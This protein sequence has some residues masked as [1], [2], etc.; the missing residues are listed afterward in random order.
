M[1]LSTHKITNLGYF[2]AITL[3]VSCNCRPKLKALKNSDLETN[4]KKALSIDKLQPPDHLEGVRF[5]QDGMLNKD[6]HKEAFIGN[7]EEIDEE[8]AE[9]ADSKLKDIFNK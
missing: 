5:E 4:S 7:H 9:I 8:P 6:F 2:I 3:F 1:Y